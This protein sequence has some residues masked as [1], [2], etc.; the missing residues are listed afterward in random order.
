MHK[1]SPKHVLKVYSY[2]L[3]ENLNISDNDTQL[4]YILKYIPK[5][6]ITRI[7]DAGCGNGK[8]AEKLINLGYKN[9]FGLDLFYTLNNIH[10]KY[11]TGSIDKMQYNNAFFGFVYCNSSIYYL[12]DLNSGFLELNRILDKNGILLITVPTKHSLF[13]LWRRFKL[14]L[15][16]KSMDHLKGVKFYSRKEYIKLLEK[17]NFDVILVDG[18]NLSFI[19]YPLYHKLARFCELYFLFKLPLLR[20]RVTKC[21]LIAR[22]K[23]I[24]GYHMIIV[25]KKR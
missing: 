4:L 22:I 1:I 9:V 3:T 5:N 11:V 6:K 2:L 23:S 16:F 25:A 12:S 24:C 17:N 7:L 13:T 20:N 14:Y 10:F 15:G 19:I 21:T 18:Y 8:Y